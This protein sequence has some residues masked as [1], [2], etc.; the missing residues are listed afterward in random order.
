MPVLNGQTADVVLKGAMALLGVLIV[1]IG[2]LAANKTSIP[3]EYTTIM[4]ALIGLIVGSRVIPPDVSARIKQEPTTAA[5]RV[6]QEN[7][8]ARDQR[9]D[10]ATTAREI[11]RHAP[12]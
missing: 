6:V 10:E 5:E 7:D 8:A 9:Q 1:G 4:G 3:P 2:I 12:K 11:K